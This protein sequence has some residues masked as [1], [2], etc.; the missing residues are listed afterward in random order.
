MI[1]AG[2]KLKIKIASAKHSVRILSNVYTIY[3]NYE[4]LI[5]ARERLKML[6]SIEDLFIICKN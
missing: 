4:E 1:T 2:A 5:Q 3:E 6:E